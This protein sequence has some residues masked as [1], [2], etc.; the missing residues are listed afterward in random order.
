VLLLV[1]GCTK[2]PEHIIGEDTMKRML[3]DL[4]KAEAIMEDNEKTFYNDS[5]RKA[6]RQSVFM[7]Y[8]VTQELYDT[9]LIWY[10][11]NLDVYKTIC[12]DVV[13]ELCK[14]HKACGVILDAMDKSELFKTVILDGALPRKTFS[15]GDACDKRF[16]NEARIINYDI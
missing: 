7:K 6:L 15:M 8:N 9:T 12:D 16:Y 3:V 2:T 14:K 10:A 4:Y 5:L 11:H 13:K 1:A